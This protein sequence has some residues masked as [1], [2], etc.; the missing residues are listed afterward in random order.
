MELINKYKGLFIVLAIIHLFFNLFG[1]SMNNKIVKEQHAR[2][3][4]VQN[5]SGN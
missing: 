2:E 3:G 4:I 1:Y 5:F